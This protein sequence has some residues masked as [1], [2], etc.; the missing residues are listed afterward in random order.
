MIARGGIVDRDD[1]TKWAG[2]ELLIPR[3]IPALFAPLPP[4]PSP[5]PAPRLFRL[6]LGLWRRG[7]TLKCG[8]VTLVSFNVGAVEA[9]GW[10]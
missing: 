6:T 8:F 9:G 2:G 4:C 5:L 10:D 1:S 7:G 3:R